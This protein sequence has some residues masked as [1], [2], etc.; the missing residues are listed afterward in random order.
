[1]K[2]WEDI[3]AEHR[4][5]T[6]ADDLVAY[7]GNIG[8]AVSELADYNVSIYTSEQIEYA[9]K[10]TELT[11]Q[12]VREFGLEPADDFEA[13]A[14]QAGV[15]A[16]YQSNKDEIYDNL[17]DGI[18]LCVLDELEKAHEGEPFNERAWECMLELKTY[19]WDDT[20]VSIE[21]VTGEALDLYND[22]CD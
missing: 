14:A 20:N 3:K 2:T 18:T 12:A 13:Y 8:D 5:E 6:Y 1:M 17:E 11:A 10:D 9:F 22:Y 21:D 19:D 15:C 16:W 7:S 4:T